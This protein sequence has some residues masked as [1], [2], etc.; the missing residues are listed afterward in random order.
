[1]QKSLGGNGKKNGPRQLKCE[2]SGWN[3]GK[4]KKGR[5]RETLTTGK[6]GTGGG[7]SGI[8]E[9][10]KGGGRFG[11]GHRLGTTKLGGGV[12]PKTLDGERKTKKRVQD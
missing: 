11:R 7:G 3:W 8:Q 1:V 5:W 6:V 2:K 10:T 12:Q 4:R 9:R